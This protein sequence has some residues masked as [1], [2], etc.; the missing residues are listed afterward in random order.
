MRIWAGY[1]IPGSWEHG[2]IFRR[3]DARSIMKTSKRFLFGVLSSLLLAVGFAHAADRIDPMNS[4]ASLSSMDA[5]KAETLK[6]KGNMPCI[7]IEPPQ[8]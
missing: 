8:N 4:K 2:A 7:I 5:S 1:R 6:A 3:V